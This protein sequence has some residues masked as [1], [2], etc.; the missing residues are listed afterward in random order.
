[1]NT[2]STPAVTYRRALVTFLD[3]L[4]FGELVK[5]SDAQKIKHVLNIVAEFT[6]EDQNDRDEF[7]PTSVAFSDSIV[8]VRFLDGTNLQQPMG[9]P[10]HE[11]LDMVHAQGELIKYGVV[12]RGA[13]TVG[14]IYVDGQTIFGPALV[15]AYE[16]ESKV[17]LYPR[18][19]VDPDLLNA[20]K[21]DRTLGTAHHTPTTDRRYIRNLLTRGEN[22]FWFVDY[23]RAS[24]AELDDPELEVKY[25]LDH[26]R[27]V[28]ERHNNSQ[29]RAMALDKILWL[30]NYHNKRVSVLSDKWFNHYQVS[31]IQF[32]ITTKEIPELA[33]L[34]RRR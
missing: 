8:R 10:F 15:R 30:A 27:L 32:E 13:I 22:G 34:P 33:R 20:T 16:L 12:L 29:T 25:L 19:V 24:S 21:I 18:V 28:L 3:I 26:K 17:A 14:N 1:M 11:L 5:T 31:R 23:L 2:K 4:G 6:R 7:S 9:L